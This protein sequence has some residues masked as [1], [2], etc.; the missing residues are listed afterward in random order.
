MKQIFFILSIM[1]LGGCTSFEADRQ[2]EYALDLAGTNRSELE[3]VLKHYEND[4]LK[5]EA[6]KFLIRNM[7]G[8]YSYS[9][10]SVVLRYSQAVDSILL[11]MKDSSSSYIADSI[12]ACANRM[13]MPKLKKVQDIKI[14]T[15]QYLI[16]NIDVAFD[17][18]QKGQWAQ[19]LAFDEFCEYLLPYKVEELQ[20]LDDWRF[21]LKK[22]PIQEFAGIESL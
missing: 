17:D 4:S 21:R 10:T 6:A 3:I 14:M 12:N 18:W 8:H 5:L 13:G 15:A 9:D 19:H 1:L 7:P 16:K 22:I 2:L 11:A 20:L